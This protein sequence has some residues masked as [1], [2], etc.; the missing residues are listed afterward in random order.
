MKSVQYDMKEVNR[1]LGEKIAN[2]EI[3]LANEQAAKQAIIKYAEELEG[4]LESH[5]NHEGTQI[6]EEEE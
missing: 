6:I 1:K 3:H 4:Q 2:L 5:Q